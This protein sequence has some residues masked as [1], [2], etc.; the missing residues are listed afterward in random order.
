MTIAKIKGKREDLGLSQKQLAKI[1]KIRTFKL[2]KIENGTIF[3]DIVTIYELCKILNI[4][5]KF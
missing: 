5:V 1:V 2:A 4:K 3:G